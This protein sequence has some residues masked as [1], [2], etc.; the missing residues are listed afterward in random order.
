MLSVDL[1]SHS[2]DYLARFDEAVRERLRN[3]GFEIHPAPP[4][5]PSFEFLVHYI[6]TPEI[7]KAVAYAI[8]GESV[9][10]EDITSLADEAFSEDITQTQLYSPTTFSLSIHAAAGEHGVSLIDGQELNL[11]GSQETGSDDDFEFDLPPLEMDSDS[12]GNPSVDLP[13]LE[14]PAEP[15]AQESAS[16]GFSDQPDLNLPEL[17]APERIQ[18][19]PVAEAPREEESPQVSEPE[20]A[21]DSGFQIRATSSEDSFAQ[22]RPQTQPL[23]HADA[24]DVSAPIQSDPPAAAEAPA[25]VPVIANL[26]RTLAQPQNNGVDDDSDAGSLPSATI[27]IKPMDLEDD[28]LPS[29]TIPIQPVGAS[30]PPPAQGVVHESPAQTHL[31][32][33]QQN[34]T[35]AE[36]EEKFPWLKEGQQPLAPPPETA[37]PYAEQGPVQTGQIPTQPAPTAPLPGQPIPTGPLPGQPVQTAPL[38]G[39]PSQT[40]TVPVPAGTAPLS[41]ESIGYAATPP[42][43]TPFEQN[44]PE[45]KPRRS[46]SNP[47]VKKLVSRIIAAAALI[48]FAFVLYQ[49]RLYTGNFI[50]DTVDVVKTNMGME[51][52]TTEVPQSELP[53]YSLPIISASPL[54]ATTEKKRTM[55]YFLTR[56]GVDTFAEPAIQKLGLKLAERYSKEVP[57]FSFDP[58]VSAVKTVW[59]EV[60]KH[61]RVAS[62]LLYDIFDK[63]IRLKAAESLIPEVEKIGDPVLVFHAKA[64]RAELTRKPDHV[65][66]AIDAA[67]EMLYEADGLKELPVSARV[68]T[69]C[70]RPATA[71]Y[72]ENGAEFVDAVEGASALDPWLKNL[73]RGQYH[74]TN[75]QKA[76]SNKGIKKVLS[77]EWWSYPEE[78]M[79]ARLALKESWELEPGEPYAASLMIEVAMDL[80]VPRED[81]KVWFERA[82]DAQGDH[83]ESYDRYMQTLLPERGGSD[84]ELAAFGIACLE[85]GNFSTC[86]PAKLIKTHELRSK[87]WADETD[88]WRNRSDEEI[89]DLEYMIQGYVDASDSSELKNYYKSLDVAL[90]YLTGKQRR[91]RA[92]L[93]GLM[94]DFDGFAVKDFSFDSDALFEALR[95]DRLPIAQTT[96]T[97][98]D[99]KES[100]E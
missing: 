77:S 79:Q 75:A 44:V 98:N 84:A 62:A 27:P 42:S 9:T 15:V 58:H 45:L 54:W 94:D 25:T 31:V 100:Q 49:T 71:L 3:Y 80:H 5:L 33:H 89:A 78:L 21:T 32:S 36:A 38:P 39:Y 76:L 22:S 68:A 11:I 23:N 13:P 41:A 10:A 34:Q 12:G 24:E 81:P 51:E 83:S 85:T 87:D 56:H 91:A 20:P 63:R 18:P 82:I 17:A 86:V 52:R 88:Y 59:K 97:P 7:R 16:S 8:E 28:S 4:E 43:S 2:P 35:N 61:P 26:S 64:V 19:R 67:A 93:I 14:Q 95:V 50:L 74:L 29:M 72:E 60:D 92:V 47:K 70:K 96:A 46:G 65:K 53:A 69:L 48:A 66:E 6:P 40:G 55:D 37:P 99:E 30:V 73:V 90:A 1:D 57:G